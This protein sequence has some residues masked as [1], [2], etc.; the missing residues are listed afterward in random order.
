MAIIGVWSILTGSYEYVAFS[1]AFTHTSFQCVYDWIPLSKMAWCAGFG[2]QFWEG[3]RSLIPQDEG[4]LDRKPLYD[5]Y[6][7]VNCSAVFF[8][9]RNRFSLAHT[10]RLRSS[11]SS[12]TITTFLGAGTLALREV[13]WR[14]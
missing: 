13:I 11:L 12:L 9:S 5:A 6:H 8:S 2:P 4:F 7:Q 14:I 1:A 10:S 3:Y